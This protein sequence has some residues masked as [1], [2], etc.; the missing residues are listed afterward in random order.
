[1][2][3]TTHSVVASRA[4]TIIELLVA[5][6]VTLLVLFL[7]SRLFFDTAGVVGQ[8]AMLSDI[9]AS[10]RMVS[11]QLQSDAEAM[12]TPAAPGSTGGF[13]VII[14]QVISNVPVRTRT[15][16]NA[17]STSRDTRSDQLVF[18]RDAKGAEG[19]PPLAPGA[20]NAYANDVPEDYARVWYGH[21]LKTNPD[22]SDPAGDLGTAPN[23]IG[24]NWVLG[25][26]ALLLTNTGPANPSNIYVDG[27]FWNSN[28]NGTGLATT[29][30]LYQGISDASNWGL[31]GASGFS[32]MEH[33]YPGVALPEGV[34]Q[35]QAYRYAFSPTTIEDGRRLRVNPIPGVASGA[36]TASYESWRVGQ[37]HGYLMSNVSDFVVEFAADTNHDNAVDVDDYG[38]LRWYGLGNMPEWSAAYTYNATDQNYGGNEV[39]FVFRHD[40]ADNWPYLIRVRYRLHDPLGKQEQWVGD[41]ATGGPQSGMWFEQVIRVNRP[42]P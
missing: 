10:S 35:I 27:A 30:Q 40:Y 36:L 13:L 38:H 28:V 4:F 37:T 22:G 3:R 14:N 19:L 6:T 32:V 24:T 34:Y 1:M 31:N 18:I 25:R 29:P 11:E 16:P 8:G 23:D 42:H 33:L 41:S 12:T 39:R 20:A 5:L 9:I 26:Q 15:D 17:L 2:T 21:A 7:V